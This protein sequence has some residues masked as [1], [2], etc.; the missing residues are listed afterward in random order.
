MADLLSPSL[1]FSGTLLGT[2]S[3]L[4]R[5]NA[6]LALGRKKQAANE[7][8]AQQLEQEGQQSVGIG[9]RN[10]SDVVRNVS[11]VNSAAL[12]R[13]AASGAGASDPTVLKVLAQ[14]AGEGA[15]RQALAMYEGEA[16]QRLDQMRASALRFEGN[17]NVNEAQAAKKQAD[18]GAASTL[19]SGAAKAYSMFDKYWSS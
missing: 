8:E 7:F 3:D 13:A 10:A 19:L 15:Y 1:Q 4:A 5:G 2:A 17:M 18:F 6:A 12:A 11:L 9:M 14:T 16:Q